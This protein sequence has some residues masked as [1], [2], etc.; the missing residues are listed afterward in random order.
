MNEEFLKIIAIIILTAVFSVT[1][2]KSRPEYSF[3]LIL[4]A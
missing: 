1:L 4:F 3:L 2:R